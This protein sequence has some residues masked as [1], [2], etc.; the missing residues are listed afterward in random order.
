MPVIGLDPRAIPLPEL[1]GSLALV[2]VFFQGLRLWRGREMG[3]FVEERV[4]R[5]AHRRGA[6]SVALALSL[7]TPVVLFAFDG[8]VGDLGGVD[9]APPGNTVTLTKDLTTQFQASGYATGD[10]SFTITPAVTANAAPQTVTVSNTTNVV[11]GSR[12]DVDTAAN[13]ESIVVSAVPSATQI[14]AIFQ[15]SHVAA[16]AGSNVAMQFPTDTAQLVTVGTVGATIPSGP[17][18]GGTAPTIGRGAHAIQGQNGLY[19]IA[20]GQSTANT[21][22][23]DS[24]A[25]TFSAGPT[26]GTRLVGSGAFSIQVAANTFLLVA[27]GRGDA[28]SPTPLLTD[29]IT[30]TAN[31][32][33]VAAGPDLTGAT[34]AGPGAHA[35]KRGDGN[36]VIVHG[37]TTTGTSFVTAG[38]S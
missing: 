6:V 18:A 24:V 31:S 13:A 30:A 9:A 21:T 15:K 32:F 2:A 19:L 20:N 7:A 25:N 8:G 33:T 36:F 34:G 29:V 10:I 17:F 28:G 23:Y 16:T 27:A 4:P 37:G 5:R 3:A 11:V 38:V 14:T 12:I 1:V 35:I 22:I 26:L